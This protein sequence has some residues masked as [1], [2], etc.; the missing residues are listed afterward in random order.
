MTACDRAR[1]RLPVSGEPY[2]RMVLVK[3]RHAMNSLRSALFPQVAAM[4]APHLVTLL[5]TGVT[6]PPSGQ[7]VRSVKLVANEAR[8]G[9]AVARGRSCRSAGSAPRH[10]RS[11]TCFVRYELDR[12]HP[13]SARRTGHSR[14]QQCHQ[15]RRH[16]GRYLREERG[17]QT[18]H[19]MAQLH[20]HHTHI[21]LPGNGEPFPCPVARGHARPCPAVSSRV[22][23]PF[24]Q[25]SRTLNRPRSAW[26][27]MITAKDEQN[28]KSNSHAANATYRLP[29]AHGPPTDTRTPTG[30][31]SAT[32]KLNQ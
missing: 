25:R 14:D 18:V 27:R 1:K 4:M 17:P 29:L 7:G 13:L 16:H 10:R 19:C 12:S 20:Q 21:R 9:S 24:P 28:V 15:V 6:S 3:L 26:V 22:L 23:S 30:M 11:S 31:V 5:I 8:R 32:I 2:V